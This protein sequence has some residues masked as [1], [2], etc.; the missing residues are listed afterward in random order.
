MTLPDYLIP[1]DVHITN[2]DS[3]YEYNKL[4]R[5]LWLY[6]SAKKMSRSIIIPGLIQT[7][8]VDG[9][10][11]FCIG[12]SFVP[13]G[14]CV[15]QKYILIS[16]YD[17]E[18]KRNSVI[19]VIDKKSGEYVT[20]IITPGTAHAGG[21]AYDDVNKFI[22]ISNGRGVAGFPYEALSTCVNNK[23]EYTA[24]KLTR[25]FKTFDTLTQ[26]SYC[27]FYNGILWVGSFSSRRKGEAYGYHY[28]L[29]DVKPTPVYYMKVPRFIQGMAFYKVGEKLHLSLSA[30]YGIQ[31]SKLITYATE[32]PKW[33]REL[34][35]ITLPKPVNKRTFPSKSEAIAIA[36]NTLLV[37]YESAAYC[38]R[39]GIP[40]NKY[41]SVHVDRILGYDI[42]S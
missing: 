27:S 5:S 3:I 6:P 29:N 34:T 11:I 20:T 40:L 39:E 31:N 1:T 10:G 26:A 4:L 17:K 36:D 12:K 2:S 21:M 32:L 30:S 7:V 37:L 33:N 41:L 28:S 14:M 38:Y 42:D 35:A 23:N 18:Y 25:Y 15:A 24:F 16:A 9:G 22:W 13:Q 8:S 19:Y